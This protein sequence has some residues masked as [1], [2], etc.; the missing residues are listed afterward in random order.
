M[1]NQA[2][3]KRIAVLAGDGIGPEVTAQSVRVLRWFH[4]NSEA[5]F[6]IEELD[7]GAERVLRD[8]VTLPANEIARVR[9]DCDAVLFGALGDPRI[10]DM[11]HGREILLA[12]R[13]EL[14]LYLNV[15]PALCLSDRLCPLRGRSASDIDFVILRE[16]TEGGYGGSTRWR[17]P[18]E[19]DEVA[20]HEATHSR[21]R[22]ERTLRAA[23]ELASNRRCPRLTLADKSNAIDAHRLW[24]DV[25]EEL[26]EHWP[27]VDADAMYADTVAH[28][29][30]RDP[31]GFEVIVTTNM[32]GDILSDI[33][34]A[35]QGGLGVA[36]SANLHPGRVSLFEPV[37]GSAPRLAGKGLGN[38]VAS[39]LST[40][41]MLEQL[42]CSEPGSA[43]RTAVQDTIASGVAT[44]DLGGEA[45]T[46][47]VGTA[48]IERLLAAKE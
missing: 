7:Y 46:D 17:S 37:H 24:R 29:L 33:G 2:R 27:D 3:P 39:L 21:P 22:I 11:H 48:V 18:G 9:R 35:L 15:R 1:R 38:P 5:S 45:N 42:G 30:I 6:T 47:Q 26:S 36:P 19:S 12:L 32:L 23:F 8:G 34:A 28:E 43:L 4:E 16:N 14:D 44:P 10:P 31:A 41:M 25:F 13:Q 20:V 40:A